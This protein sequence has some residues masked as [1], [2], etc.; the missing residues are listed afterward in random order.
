M[1]V[2]SNTEH[3]VLN[4]MNDNY[5][6]KRVAQA[7]ADLLDS[8]FNAAF[9]IGAEDG[10]NNITVSIQLSN[11]HGEALDSVQAVTVYLFA[12]AAGTAFNTNNY[13]ISAGSDGAV[14]EVVADKILACTCEADGD[15]D[16]V[17]QIAGAATCY[18]GVLLPG[19]KLA[20]SDAITHA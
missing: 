19:G 13:T 8:A 20:I 4:R 2:P 7:I 11:E 14:A 10:S 18:L 1:S 17:L 3:L 15:L 5:T 12:N 16:I 6:G 9:S